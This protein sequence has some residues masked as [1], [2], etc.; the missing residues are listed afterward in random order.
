[1]KISNVQKIPILPL[2]L[3]IKEGKNW[4]F[5]FAKGKRITNATHDGMCRASYDNNTASG[6]HKSQSEVH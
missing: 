1:M 6:G 2:I 4:G 3:Y 5:F